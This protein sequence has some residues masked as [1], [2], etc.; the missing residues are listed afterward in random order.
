MNYGMT[1][2]EMLVVLGIFTFS[3]ISLTGSIFYFYRSNTYAVEQT[4]AINS[5]RRGIEE[6]VRDLREMTYSEE[7]AYPISNMGAD[8]I[9][10]YADVD[11]T[12]DVERV[13]YYL[14][15]DLLMKGVIKATGNPLA[16]TGAETATIVSEYVRNVDK[17]VNIFQYK[18]E[19]GVIINNFSETQDVR[20]VTATLV[21][22][23]NP[24]RLPEEFL[25]TGS[26]TLRNLKDL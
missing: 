23:V 17:G 1:L 14:Q 20:F 6:L 24:N 18:D 9:T 12:S 11:S 22:N 13:R 3:M 25:L 4:A 8:T 26:A 21:V 19:S 7:G 16:Y 15:S 10:F 5:G 2:V